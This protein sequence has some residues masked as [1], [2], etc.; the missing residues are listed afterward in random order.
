LRPPGGRV[1]FIPV[2]DKDGLTW[3]DKYVR[4][5]AEALAIDKDIR[6]PTK[7]KIN[8]ESKKREL[9]AGGRRVYEVEMMLDPVAAGSRPACRTRRDTLSTFK[10]PDCESPS[11]T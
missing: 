10:Q 1:R 9:N 4:T 6:D 7:R 5:D 3:P 11:L 2:L 8:L